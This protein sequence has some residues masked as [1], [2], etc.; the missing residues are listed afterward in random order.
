MLRLG[1]NLLLAWLLFPEAFG[2]MA[3][4]NV[5]MHGLQMISDTGIR[6]SILYHRRG[7]HQSF[8]DTA[9]TVQIVRGIVLWICSCLIAIPVMM[10]YGEP[11]LGQLLPVAGL[12][13]IIAGFNSTALFTLNRRVALGRITLLDV[14]SQVASISVMVSDGYR[15]VRTSRPCG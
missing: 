1:S 11:M 12:T 8:L 14:L 2:L 5:F 13:A 3:L 9:W 15:Q 4:V 7:D 6:G 10:L